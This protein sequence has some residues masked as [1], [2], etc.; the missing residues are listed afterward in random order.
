MVEG[1]WFSRRTLGIDDPLSTIDDPR[2]LRCPREGEL[3][4]GARA[5]V[6]RAQPLRAFVLLG[7]RQSS[8]DADVALEETTQQF[9]AVA[10]AAAVKQDDVA[11]QSSAGALAAI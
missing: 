10:L 8:A 2:C 3:F 11:G 5:D 9:R 7:E 1:D 4:A 6:R